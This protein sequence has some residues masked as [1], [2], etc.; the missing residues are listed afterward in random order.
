[1]KVIFEYKD[2]TYRIVPTTL[3][4][5][6]ERT[7][8]NC[9]IDEYIMDIDLKNMYIISDDNDLG[10]FLVHKDLKEIEEKAKEYKENLKNLYKSKAFYGR[11]IERS[12]HTAK[13]NKFVDTIEEISEKTIKEFP[14][15]Q[16]EYSKLLEEEAKRKFKE[17]KKVS[18]IDKYFDFLWSK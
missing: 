15:E 9:L 8:A 12:R 10:P 5:I 6:E 14:Y 11:L 4:K 18:L 2:G 13:F 3:S 7:Q 16:E 17:T 1:M